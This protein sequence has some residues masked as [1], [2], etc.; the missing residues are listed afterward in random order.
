[1]FRGIPLLS[2][3]TDPG[4]PVCASE[5]TLYKVSD[6]AKQYRDLDNQA[7]QKELLV[8]IAFI[9]AAVVVAIGTAIAIYYCCTGS[10]TVTDKL[11]KIMTMS[12]A[13][14]SVVP[15]L[16][17]GLGV[18]GLITGAIVINF[19][20]CRNGRKNNR[21]QAGEH[22]ERVHI[23]TTQDLGAI[24]ALYYKKNGGFKHLVREGYMTE[25]QSNTMRTTL[26]L[27]DQ[28]MQKRAKYTSQP[29]VKAAIDEGRAQPTEY[30]D[31]GKEMEHLQGIWKGIQQAIKTQYQGGAV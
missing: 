23:L 11:G 26:N 12:L 21:D 6:Q 31:A 17:G 8:R 5:A 7:K 4:A 3:A 29:L 14:I 20:A 15:G 25:I 28:Q 10:A 9:V 18:I 1:M 19:E 16:L 13:P 2:M 27:Y 24:H 30:V 22:A